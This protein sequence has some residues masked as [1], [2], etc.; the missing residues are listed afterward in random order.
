[1]EDLK[2]KFPLVRI[3]W[4]DAETDNSW[5]SLDQVNKE[6]VGD[7]VVTVG[8]LIRKPNK[9]FPMYMVASTVTQGDDPHF[10][11]I[12][13]IPKVWVVSVEDLGDNKNNERHGKE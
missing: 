10:N 8:F 2:I 1:M 9:R 7:P 4:V 3:L 5:N 6:E 13:K 12:I 11:A